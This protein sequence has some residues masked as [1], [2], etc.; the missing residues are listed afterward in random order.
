MRSHLGNR[1]RKK[2]DEVSEPSS[3]CTMQ[4]MRVELNCRFDLEKFLWHCGVCDIAVYN[5]QRAKIIIIVIL[6]AWSPDTSEQ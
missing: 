6:R 3:S 5:G 4:F 2:G 1:F